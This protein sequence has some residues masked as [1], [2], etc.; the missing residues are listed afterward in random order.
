VILRELP[1][2]L[3]GPIS[4]RPLRIAL[5]ALVVGALGITG[6]FRFAVD[7]GQS[8]LVG[9]SSTAGQQYASFA[10]KFGSDPI[11]VVFTA[12][13]AA[14]PYF[15][16]NLRRLGALEI[17]LA[18]DPRVA[19]VLGPGTVAASLTEA[20]VAEVNKVLTEYPYFIAET[21][22]LSLIQQGTSMTQQQLTQ[23]LQSDISNAQ[24]LIE[25]Y[26]V[27]A[28]RDAILARA[29]YKSK[30]G[31]QIIDAQEKAVDAAVA[32]DPVPPLWAEY[33]A[34]PGRTPDT[35]QAM[36][37]FDRFAAAY[38]ACDT[39]IASLLSV[40]NDCQAFFERSL[41]DLPHCPV[42]GTPGSFCNPK[43]QWS[44]VLPAPQAG[45]VAYQILT[46]RV[47]PQYVGDRA[48]I[49]SLRDKISGELAHGIADDAFTKSL[50]AQSLSTLRS[51]GPLRPS[52]CAGQTQ[53]QNPQCFSAYKDAPMA[54]VMA[55][56]PLL[57]AG[58]VN[59]MQTLL[60]I[61]FPVAFFVMLLLLIG[62]FRVRGRVWALLA[63]L[64]ATVL[65]VGLGLLTGTPIT[66][67]VL[68]GVPILL[69]L[70]V[71]YAVQ[72]VARFAE[73]R[74]RGTEVEGAVRAA[75]GNTGT[76]T[77]V[78]AIAT[79]V[80]LLALALF[81]GIDWGPLVAIPLVA[82]FAIV[83]AGGI[84]L[85][86]LAALFVALPLSVWSDRRRS[87]AAALP[88]RADEKPASTPAARTIAIAD[89]WIGVVA[90]LGVIALAGWALLHAVPVQTDVQKLVSQSLSELT[91]IQMVQ[92][93]TGYTNEIDIFVRGQVATG[94]VDAKTGNPDNVEWQCQAAHDILSGH[95]HQV[96]QAVSIGDFFI[97][98]STRSAGSST[99][100]CVSTLQNPQPSP[101]PGGTPTPTPTPSATPSSPA[102]P[103]ASASPSG[104]HQTPGE[105]TVASRHVA[106][107]AA[108]TPT[109]SPSAA[110]TPLPTASTSPRASASAS[111]SASPQ[112][113]G[114]QATTQTLFLCDLRLFPL[115]THS[116]VM[117]I[118]IDNPPCPAV[119]KYRNTFISNDGGPINPDSARIA[120]GVNSP[121]V[122]DEA[123]L[124]DSL[125]GEVTT[126]PNGL[127]AAPTGLAVL[128]TTAYDNIVGRAYLLNLAPLLIVAV[129]LFLIYREPRRALLPLL[130]TAMAAGW[131][132]LVLLVLGRLPGDL[133]STLGSLNPLTVVLGAL[134]IALGTE[135]GVVLLGRFYEE[136][137]E[138]LDPEAA[139][140]A[141]LA[142]VG[143]AIR[144]SALTLGAGFAV[145]GLSGL[146][147]NSLPLVAD[148]GLAVVIDLALAVGAVFLVML[149][150]AVVIERRAP[151]R[152][153]VALQ[154][155]PA[156]PKTA[157]RSATRRKAEPAP[158]SAEIVE[159]S[160]TEVPAEADAGEQPAEPERP[161]TAGPPRRQPGV[162][163]RRRAQRE[164]DEDESEPPP[165]EEKRR[166]GISGRRRN[167]NRG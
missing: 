44:A 110:T 108:T 84:V 77:L 95:S 74:A 94:P 76:A 118:G 164:D 29:Q 126:A 34:G 98:S 64:A 83:L 37:V 161:P 31:D 68:A 81:A 103:S 67:A 55:G 82:E 106:Q 93:E 124:V 115:L 132:P 53:Q 104:L 7:S 121:S 127:T 2:R 142:G 91:D 145:L 28:A 20:A 155:A 3:V 139:A 85:A 56:A 158:R 114:A 50:S 72:L 75:V 16:Q 137:R 105:A 88:P 156:A 122:A 1:L 4:R 59:S 69:G 54:F 99:P 102:S 41:L 135:F 152:L 58:V 15:E 25:L 87:A 153:A 18:H 39:Q 61:L 113:G 90:P 133:G 109:P 100:T 167:R 160:E 130:P 38:G 11:V 22:I 157:V 148:F 119:D 154:R 48:Q 71:D 23:R 40:P 151:L 66:P 26:V 70:G 96:S 150:V 46:I 166:P 45:G 49:A 112:P 5:V 63:A 27:K 19:S 129:A 149:P 21:D 111:A 14:A 101:S 47:K 136:R 163:G 79:L 13:D 165:V 92:A 123:K 62:T 141:A 128:A 138:G 131:A 116:L 43:P 80:G 120:L 65:T 117:D 73:E 33:L 86:W 51:L 10:Q 147:P 12:Q 32:P 6:L 52:E 9:S 42:M 89:N 97:G 134:V 57:G 36:Q 159:T 140:A 144:V 107:Q 30:P 78:A 125:R 24:S 17:D 146:F 60:L 35:A 8:L 143:R 162:S